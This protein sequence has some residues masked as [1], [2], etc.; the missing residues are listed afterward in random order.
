[1]TQIVI[2]IRGGAEDQVTPLWARY[3]ER[4]ARHASQ[5]LPL[6]LRTEDEDVALSVMDAFCDGLAQGKFDFVDRREVLWRTLATITERKVYRRVERWEKRPAHFTDLR[7]DGASSGGGT[8]WIASLQPTE[9]YAAIVRLELDELIR[10]LPNPFW[11]QAAW[12]AMEGYSAAEIAG[13][14]NRSTS[15]VHVWFRTIR[16]IWEDD[17]GRE[18]SLG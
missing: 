2:D 1:M 16:S 10:K 17:P 3:F 5:R 15:M 14:L 9:E 6:P 12:M 11:R 8:A 18:N 13:K 7:C 4:L